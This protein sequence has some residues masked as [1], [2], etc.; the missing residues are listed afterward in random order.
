MPTYQETQQKV[1]E[2]RALFEAFAR[3]LAEAFPERTGF[4]FSASI[5]GPDHFGNVSANFTVQ[6]EDPITPEQAKERRL[7]I[8][9]RGFMA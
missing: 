3:D 5:V 8:F 2:I 9:G 6:T 4:S 1:D 7:P